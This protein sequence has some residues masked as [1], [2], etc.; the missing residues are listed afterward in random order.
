MYLHW[1]KKVAIGLL[2]GFG[3]GV[4]LFLLPGTIDGSQTTPPYMTIWIVLNYVGL[5]VWLFIWIADQARM[6][7]K[8]IWV[9]LLPTVL[10]PLPTLMGFLIYLQ[11]R[12]S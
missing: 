12:M 1:S 5:L 8:H 11:K 9:W 2:A 3:V 7:G 4:A 6:R 10:A